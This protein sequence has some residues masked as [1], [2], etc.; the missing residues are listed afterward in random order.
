MTSVF[1][2]FSHPSFFNRHMV[3]QTPLYG[4]PLNTDTSLLRTVRFAPEKRE[5][6]SRINFPKFISL[7]AETWL[8]WAH[9]MAPSLSWLTGFESFYFFRSCV[10]INL[11]RIY[12]RMIVDD[13]FL[14]S[15]GFLLVQE[16][17]SWLINNFSRISFGIGFNGK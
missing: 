17:E 10:P 9:S 2:L 14:F 15:K 13:F 7:N 4:Q 8:I 1:I 3:S 5:P 16:R 11:F 12:F 6:V